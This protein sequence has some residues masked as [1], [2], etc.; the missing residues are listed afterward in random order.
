MRGKRGIA[1]LVVLWALLLL[2]LLGMSFAFAMRT[3]AQAARNGLDGARAYYQARTG[4]NRALALLS[5][6]PLDN[7]L[8]TSIAGGDDD[9]SY[10]VTISGEGGK[11]DLNRISEEALKEVLRR[12]GLP[13]EEAE[14]VGDSILDWRDEDDMPRAN[15]AEFPYY[16]SLPEPL[17]P[18]NGKLAAVDELLSVKGVTPDLYGRFLSKVFTVHGNSPS[19]DI[20]Q[21]PVEVLRVLPGI[22]AEAADAIVTLRRDN[23]FRSPAEVATFLSGQDLPLTAIPMVSISSAARVYAITSVGVAGGK[24]A[25]GVSCRVEIGAGGPKSVKILRWM[26]YVAA[27]GGN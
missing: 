13:P 15:G 7:V 24:I 21:A 26:D 2:G 14:N 18:R 12:G 10:E 19:V 9:A 8:R 1:L 22:T 3:E 16:G 23:P 25:R 27:G 11:F 6:S 5:S 17:K 20:N 4:I